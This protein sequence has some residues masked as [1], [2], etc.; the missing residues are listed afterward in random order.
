[1]VIGT[2]GQPSSDD[3]VVAIYHVALPQVYGYLLP[4]CGSVAV[5]ED[6]TA[7]P[8]K[9]A[10]DA[11]RG[12]RVRELTVAWLVGSCSRPARATTNGPWRSEPAAQ[13]I[14]TT[15]EEEGR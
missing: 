13:L 7:E 6:L 14:E 3:P 4:R 2:E 15:P 12:G 10:V 5:A 1:L 9:A 11:V 8:F